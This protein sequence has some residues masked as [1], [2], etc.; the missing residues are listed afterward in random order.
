M[1]TTQ[2]LVTGLLVLGLGLAQQHV[3]AQTENFTRVYMAETQWGEI[4]SYAPDGTD[5]QILSRLSGMGMFNPKSVAVDVGR[6]EIY[7]T[8]IGGQ[9]GQVTGIAKG[10]LDGSGHLDGSGIEKLVTAD[11]DGTGGSLAFVLDLVSVPNKM[12]WAD[13]GNLR[14]RRSD[15]SGDNIEILVSLDPDVCRSL[16]LDIPGGKLYWTIYSSPDGPK[17]QRTD[18]DMPI[19]ETPE[20]RTIDT[21]LTYSNGL[22]A[23]RGI[24]V[25]PSVSGKM[26]WN[27]ASY[28]TVNRADKAIG[29]TIEVIVPAQAGGSHSNPQGIS[30]DLAANKL[31]WLDSGVSNHK[32]QRVDLGTLVVDPLVEDVDSGSSPNSPPG[33]RYITNS[34]RGVFIEPT[35]EMVYWADANQDKVFRAP[36]VVP[37]DPSHREDLEVLAR[38]WWPRRMALDVAR[39][40]IYWADYDANAIL[41]ADLPDGANPMPLVLEEG[42]DVSKPHGIALDLVGR[43]LY[44][45]EE[46]AQAG[47][48]DIRRCKMELDGQT[49]GQRTDIE[50]VVTEIHA[51][52]EIAL[53]VPNK[54]IYWADRGTQRIQYASLVE[55]PTPTVH[56]DLLTS[57]NGLVFPNGLALDL[58]NRWLYFT[59]Y[60]AKKIRRRDLSS[61]VLQD[62]VTTDLAGPQGIALDVADNK[63]YWIDSQTDK[64]ERADIDNPEG[65]SREALVSTDLLSP[66]GIALDLWD[67]DLDDISVEVDVN[68]YVAVPAEFS[69]SDLGGSTGGTIKDYGG[70]ILT[71]VDEEP[72]PGK[73]VRITAD[74]GGGSTEADIEMNGEC[75][76]SD[77]Q[78]TPDCTDFLFGAGDSAVVTCGS[79]TIAVLTGTVEAAFVAVNG[80]TA[81][82]SIDENNALSFD[83]ETYTVTAPETNSDTIVVVVGDEEVSLGPGESVT[84]G[85]GT[86]LVEVNEHR[87]GGSSGSTVVG[88]EGM[89]VCVFDKSH[90]SCA[91][92]IG[93]SRHHYPEVFETCDRVAC[94]TTDADGLARIMLN[95]GEYLLVG[96]YDPDGYPPNDDGDERNIGVSASGFE[97]A[98]DNDPGTVTMH[99]HLQVII[100]P[101]GRTVGLNPRGG[102]GSTA[103]S[104]LTEWVE[105]TNVGWA[106]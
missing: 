34:A 90:G 36:A 2:N 23:P 68:P 93:I 31:Y 18:M 53:D 94:G 69:D 102:G 50:D 41:R 12:Y 22:R 81:T 48:G 72:N 101:N 43:W 99:K 70:Q 19:D 82:A 73:G 16:A 78:G 3:L 15:L 87:P 104:Q 10:N 61:V 77:T 59:D 71:I 75:G 63:I 74:P 106:R 97:C 65:P 14:I 84:G 88:I 76:C 17:I 7:F 32:I 21:L 1:K 24:A 92:D 96:E 55:P 42:D 37:A 44:W 33:Y 6:N 35:T 56:D 51:P 100:L 40:H 28:N 13:P 103:A 60:S 39:K 64:I 25:D 45:G 86:L 57:A 54:Q 27:D 67:A 95:A 49:P 62:L 98:P 105:I 83:P 47:E 79:V 8:G 89:Q 4:R 20:T 52:R 91:R 5:P 46:G 26:Y 66:Q 58:I 38:R 80:G 9:V 30:L 85:C 11:D 29:A